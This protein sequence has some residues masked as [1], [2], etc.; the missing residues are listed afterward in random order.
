MRNGWLRVVLF[1]VL[2]SFK[3]GYFAFDSS[4]T[5]VGFGGF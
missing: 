4:A 1:S 2:A 3:T 5:L